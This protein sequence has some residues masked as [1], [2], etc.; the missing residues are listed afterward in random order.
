MYD[1]ERMRRTVCGV[2][3]MSC[4]PDGLPSG[5]FKESWGNLHEVWCDLVMCAAMNPDDFDDDFV[6]LRL[7]LIPK[8]GSSWCSRLSTFIYY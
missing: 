5:F 2:K 4:G 1:E 6:V 3:A 7:V 8:R